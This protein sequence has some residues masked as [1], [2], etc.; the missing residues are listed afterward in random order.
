[1]LFTACKPPGSEDDA[2]PEVRKGFLEV[3]EA[4]QYVTEVRDVQVNS[5]SIARIAR[6]A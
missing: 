6:P 4:R 5:P 3:S 2:F 1:M